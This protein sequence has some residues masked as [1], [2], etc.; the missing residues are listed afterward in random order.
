MIGTGDR[1]TVDLE[2]GKATAQLGKA[3][4]AAQGVGRR[5]VDVGAKPLGLGQARRT[6]PG[7]SRGSLAT[8]PFRKRLPAL[9]GAERLDSFLEAP[10]D[11]VPGTRMRYSL[12]DA[13]ERRAVIEWLEAS[14][15]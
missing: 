8:C 12:K 6:W 14:S 11:V 13:A 5:L 15:R 3:L 4:L 9:W 10:A 7:P 1:F 2:S